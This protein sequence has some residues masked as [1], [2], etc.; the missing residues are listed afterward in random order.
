M[1]ADI[2]LHDKAAVDAEDRKRFA[3]ANEIVKAV[4][5]RK[6]ASSQTT[7][8]DKLDAVLTNPISGII[9]PHRETGKKD[10]RLASFI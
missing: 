5:T 2:D 8:H 10:L 3:F 9:I 7:G 6:V 1:Q 4:E